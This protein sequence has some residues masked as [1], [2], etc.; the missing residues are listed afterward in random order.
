MRLFRDIPGCFWYTASWIENAEMPCEER[1]EAR[2]RIL[3]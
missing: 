2:Y 1:E 3:S